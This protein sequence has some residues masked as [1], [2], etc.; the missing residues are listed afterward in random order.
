MSESNKMAAISL[1]INIVKSNNIK[2][3]QVGVVSFLASLYNEDYA[4]NLCNLIG[5][6]CNLIR[7]PL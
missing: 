5:L 7:D 1:K 6:F 4:W 2:T 3:M